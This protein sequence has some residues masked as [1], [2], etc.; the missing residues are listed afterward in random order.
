MN[1][2]VIFSAAIKLSPEQRPSFVKAACAGNP[3]LEQEV[4]ALLKEHD[5]IGS[6]IDHPAL[7][8]C[9]TELPLVSI[10]SPG[11]LIGRYKL[12][13][14]VGEGGMGVVYVAEQTEPGPPPH[15]A[16]DHQAG[17]GH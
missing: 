1:E 11:T 12:L 17:H 15:C 7:Q 4:D 10:E 8:P 16:Q 6:F 13:E 5:E 2:T 3:Q 9:A 14:Q